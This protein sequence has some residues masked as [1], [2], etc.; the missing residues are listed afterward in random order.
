MGVSGGVDACIVFSLMEG[1]S[2][3][4]REEVKAWYAPPPLPPPYRCLL[5]SFA[6]A[7]SLES[8][9][10]ERKVQTARVCSIMPPPPRPP[11]IFVEIAG[12]QQKGCACRERVCRMLVV[13]EVRIDSDPIEALV[14]VFV[15]CILSSP[16]RDESQAVMA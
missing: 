3:T 5:L 6:G 1:G 14:I 13:L 2:T 4:S 12:A 10:G 7:P 16:P 11:R 9:K 15:V 8:R